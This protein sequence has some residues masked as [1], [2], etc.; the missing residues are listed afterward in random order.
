[1]RVRCSEG[2][3]TGW[4]AASCCWVGVLSIYTRTC[5]FLH[6]CLYTSEGARSQ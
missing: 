5:V 3:R 1:M 4:L 6:L 2:M